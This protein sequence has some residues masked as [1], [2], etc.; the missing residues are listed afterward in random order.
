[1][2]KRKKQ[3]EI[4]GF[5]KASNLL[6]KDKKID[7][8]TTPSKHNEGKKT[9]SNTKAQNSSNDNRSTRSINEE[10]I[11]PNQTQDSFRTKN[12]NDT[13]FFNSTVDDQEL[14]PQ[15]NEPRIIERVNFNFYSVF[16]IRLP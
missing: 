5:T 14:E 2:T 4:I 6:P 8:K 12:L 1:M 15:N 7:S 13:D 10:S 3:I 9:R 16:T 11:D